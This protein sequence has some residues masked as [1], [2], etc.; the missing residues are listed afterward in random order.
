[1][2]NWLMMNGQPANPIYLQIEA[3][4]LSSATAS[5]TLIGFDLVY[6]CV[7]IE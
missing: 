5:P 6:D 1:M 7:P 4:L 3:H 2:G